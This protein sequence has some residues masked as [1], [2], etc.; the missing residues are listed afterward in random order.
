MKKISIFLI[1]SLLFIACAKE[2]IQPSSLYLWKPKTTD[3]RFLKAEYIKQLSDLAETLISYG[4]NVQT[5]GIGFTTNYKCTMGSCSAEENAENWLYVVLEEEPLD[6][7][8]RK[9]YDDRASFIVKTR[10][11]DVLF[12]LKKDFLVKDDPKING[13][14]ISFIWSKTMIAQENFFESIDI[15]IDIK[16]FRDYQ[17]GLIK[18]SD[19]LSRAVYIDTTNKEKKYIELSF[20]NEKEE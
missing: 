13:I 19:V 1:I 2:E 7:A 18:F 16:T 9:T 6:E 14:L 4:N 11:K 20:E 3:A 10:L 5:N 8:K 17:N 12:A 15:Y